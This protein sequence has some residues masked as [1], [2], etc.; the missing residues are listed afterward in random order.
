[1]SDF[2]VIPA[3]SAA[4]AQEHARREFE[5]RLRVGGLAV[6]EDAAMKWWPLAMTDA[7]LELDQEIQ[8]EMEADEAIEASNRRTRL[9]WERPE[10]IRP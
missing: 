1:M 10:V 6:T 7:D 5:E 4:M 8:T 3:N 9:H 2:Q